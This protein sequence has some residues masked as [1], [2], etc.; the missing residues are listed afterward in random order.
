MSRRSLLFQLSALLFAVLLAV[1]TISFVVVLLTPTPVEARMNVPQAVAALRDGEIATASGLLLS[2][3]QR[4]PP[5]PEAELL[6]PALA[7]ALGLD[8]SQFRVVWRGANRP[9]QGDVQVVDA[10]GSGRAADYH[11]VADQADLSTKAA[12]LKPALLEQRLELP[13][14]ALG[15][16]RPDQR[17][18]TLEPPDLR[19]PLWRQRLLLAVL[20]G[21][22]ALAPVAWFAARHLTKPVRALAAAAKTVDL[23]GKGAEI[24]VEGPS[25]VRAAASAFNNMQQRLKQQ[26]A[27][28]TRMIAALAHDLRTPLTGLRLRA[29]SAPPAVRERMVAD[30][31][32]MKAM[33]TRVVDYA[34]AEQAAHTTAPFDLSALVADCVR[35]AVE[36]D[37][38]VDRRLPAMAPIIGDELG[39]RRAITNLIDNATR[40]AGSAEVCLYR[41][42]GDWVIEVDDCGPGV[43]EAQ[44]D[45]LTQPFRRL[46]ESRNAHTGGVGLG[47][48]VV[49]SVALRHGGSLSLINR[50]EG[51]LRARLRIP[52]R[53]ADGESG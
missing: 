42:E 34:Q 10:S 48:A 4:P 20:L 30:I 29:E 35:A 33:I 3:Q 1:Q 6:V 51:G 19:F 25:E 18:L 38:Q 8:R 24:V 5:G 49:R 28:R 31:E 15:V 11:A 14:F 7:E 43:P 27:E 16:R 41:G 50:S 39:L 37:Q 40:Y 36:M 53:P 2:V 32:R 45:Q 13:P 44:L 9:R 47:L 52:D 21:A 12:L 23:D 17:W 26:A 22:L 46:D